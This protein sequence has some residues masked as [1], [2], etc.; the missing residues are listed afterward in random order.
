MFGLLFIGISALL[1]LTLLRCLVLVGIV[2]L[3]CVGVSALAI[4]GIAGFGLYQFFGDQYSFLIIA[5]SI[6]IGLVSAMLILRRIAAEIGIRP[7]PFKEN[8][9][10]H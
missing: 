6:A 9:H 8:H 3:V 10:A 5:A 2:V 4:A 1:F 7:T